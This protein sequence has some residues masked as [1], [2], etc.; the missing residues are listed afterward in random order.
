[1]EYNKKLYET[2]EGIAKNFKELSNKVETD[3]SLPFSEV[4]KINIQLKKHE[5]VAA[6]FL[7]LKKMVDDAKQAEDMLN[8]SSIKEPELIAMAKADLERIRTAIPT[9]EQEIKTL[10]LPVDPN[11]DK[12]VIVEMRPAAGGDE[13]ALFVSDLFDT[14]KRYFDNQK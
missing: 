6:K 12:N 4:K 5:P 1:M 14:Y 7:E 13:S 8:D 11:N 3:T 9:L 10:L 2:V